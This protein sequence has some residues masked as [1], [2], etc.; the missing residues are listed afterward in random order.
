MRQG[1]RTDPA[2]KKCGFPN[3]SER[4]PRSIFM[5]REHWHMV[6]KDLQQAVSL[7][8]RQYL[9]ATSWEKK[10]EAIEALGVAQRDAINACVWDY[11]TKNSGTISGPRSSTALPT[12]ERKL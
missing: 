4:V 9:R 7:R 2:L 11:E 12:N 6:P 8:Y 3:C 1:N 10:L 5:C